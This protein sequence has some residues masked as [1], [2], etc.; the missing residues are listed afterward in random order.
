MLLST[1]L[2]RCRFSGVESKHDQS[3]VLL[4]VNMQHQQPCAAL[5]SP[6][7]DCSFNLEI[8]MIRFLEERGITHTSICR[9]N[10][11]TR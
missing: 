2:D 6:N 8:M 10:Y 9:G 11:T 4:R 3:L 5:C 7:G 1:P